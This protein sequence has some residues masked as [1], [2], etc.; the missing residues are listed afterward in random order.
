M[1]IKNELSIKCTLNDHKN[2][3]SYNILEEYEL[4]NKSMNQSVDKLKY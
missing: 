3:I 1:D 2:Y 4:I